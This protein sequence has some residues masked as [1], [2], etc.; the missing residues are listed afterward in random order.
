VTHS[1]GHCGSSVRLVA[2]VNA[3]LINPKISRG[4]LL[5]TDGAAANGW[6]R[7]FL[8]PPYGPTPAIAFPSAM[9]WRAPR[10]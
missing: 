4:R 10:T 3:S 5:V 7:S 2:N 6:Q 1:G 8:A 9:Y